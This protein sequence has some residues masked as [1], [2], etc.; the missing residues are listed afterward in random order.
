MD[1]ALSVWDGGESGKR[2]LRTDAHARAVRGVAFAPDSGVVATA[3]D[4]GQLRLWDA[5]HA[6]LV[7]SFSGH[8]GLVL[9]KKSVWWSFSSF[10]SFFPVLFLELLIPVL[11]SIWLLPQ[12]MEVLRFGM[13]QCASSFTPLP[14]TRHQ[15]GLLHLMILEKDWFRE[16]KIHCSFNTLYCDFSYSFLSFFFLFHHCSQDGHTFALFSLI[17]SVA[18]SS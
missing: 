3:S 9:K 16:A 4:D 10:C 1:G 15:F 6:A 17:H 2:L 14:I 13:W 18:H 7:H 5:R 11:E 8:R 12:L